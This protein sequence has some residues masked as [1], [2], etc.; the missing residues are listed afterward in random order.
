[1]NKIYK[2]RQIV[3]YVFITILLLICVAYFINKFFLKDKNLKHLN[4][5]V[6]SLLCII[7][8]IMI[9]IA[10]IE[11]NYNKSLDN[12]VTNV[13]KNENYSDGLNN[14]EAKK[15]PNLFIYAIQRKIYY[16]GLLSLYKNDIEKANESFNDIDLFSKYIDPEI[17][18][19]A[20]FY[21]LIIN[22]KTNTSDIIKDNFMAK[23]FVKNNKNEKKYNLI[24][25]L[26]K[27]D[28][29]RIKQI[30]TN[31]KC[32]DEIIKDL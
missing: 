3:N 9:V 2:K 10:L 21:L 8:F 26:C 7:I 11:T 6:V 4:I 24:C 14:L 1:M 32:I 27:N 28:N 29:A 13:I 16:I 25:D 31:I 5:V 20:V 19:N 15:I 12:Y 17:Y 23:K 18:I 22:I 30:R